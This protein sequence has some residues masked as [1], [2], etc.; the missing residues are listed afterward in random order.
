MSKTPALRRADAAA[1]IVAGGQGVR[2]GGKVRK[3]YLLLSGRPLLWWSLRAFEKSPSVASVVLVVPER[4]VSLMK[5]KVRTWKFKKLLRV[6][7]GGITRADSVRQGLQAVPSS[8]KWVAVHDAVRPLVTPPLIEGVLRQ[9]R[10][11]QA[12]IAACPSRDTVKIADSQGRIR[13]S[14]ARETVWLAQ[15]PQVFNRRLLHRAHREGRTLQVTDDAQLVERLGV[16][17][18]LVA[19]SAE[20]LKVTLPIDLVLAKNIMAKNS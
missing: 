6:V 20:N 19:S 3:Q 8:L 5:R 18:K 9:A 16:K 4:D 2:F 12:A 1:V 14:P 10:R 17:V 13:S 7:P 15:T 11:H